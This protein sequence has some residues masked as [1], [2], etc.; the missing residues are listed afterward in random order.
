MNRL[1]IGI[2]PLYFAETIGRDNPYPSDGYRFEGTKVAAHVNKT[3]DP[4][5]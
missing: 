3:K 4:R 2:Q 5:G 1:A